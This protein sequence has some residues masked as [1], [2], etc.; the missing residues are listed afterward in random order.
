VSCPSAGCP[1]SEGPSAIN[2]QPSA[3]VLLEKKRL[4]CAKQELAEM[5][6]TWLLVCIYQALVLAA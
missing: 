6:A 1:V 2:E 5:E 3:M 4:G